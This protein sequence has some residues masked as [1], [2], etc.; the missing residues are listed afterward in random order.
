LRNFHTHDQESQNKVKIF[1]SSQKKDFQIRPYGAKKKEE[2][3]WDKLEQRNNKKH[4]YISKLERITR[5]NLLLRESSY[6]RHVIGS[7]RIPV[8]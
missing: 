7:L 6:E 1:P 4:T 2:H 8:N 3:R 5:S